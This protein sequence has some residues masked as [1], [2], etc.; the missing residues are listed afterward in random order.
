MA[1]RGYV[2]DPTNE[3]EFVRIPAFY[4]KTGAPQKL[5]EPVLVHTNLLKSDFDYDRIEYQLTNSPVVNETSLQNLYFSNGK[6][7]QSFSPFFQPGMEIEK[8][9]EPGTRYQISAVNLEN[10]SVIV[11]RI[12]AENHVGQKTL[13]F[14]EFASFSTLA[15]PRKKGDLQVSMELTFKT[16]V[17]QVQ[18][19][20]LHSKSKVYAY[21][22][23]LEATELIS[24]SEQIT[25]A[26]LN[27]LEDRVLPHTLFI[28]PP[29]GIRLKD[30]ST[31]TFPE[32]EELVGLNLITGQFLVRN[33]IE[34]SYYTFPI[35]GTTR[36]KAETLYYDPEYPEG[37]FVEAV[38][39]QKNFS[40]VLSIRD[41]RTGKTSKIIEHPLK[42]AVEFKRKLSN[43]AQ[44]LK[45]LSQAK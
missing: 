11:Q 1:H 26:N 15:L 40:R 16:V 8:K 3:N 43:C 25:S 20:N 13:G 41:H 34:D 22:Q 31:I 32:Y 39:V 2:E 4:I 33:R 9:N 5:A 37:Y 45:Q 29:N 14:E 18:K 38:H 24:T 19:I 30:L 6:F 17:N 10:D 21:N 44:A 42:R 23:N 35:L 7:L 12:F 27:F 36:F 28:A